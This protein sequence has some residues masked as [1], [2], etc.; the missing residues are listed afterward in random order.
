PARGRVSIRWQVPTEGLASLKVYDASG[1][2]VRTLHNGRTRPGAYRSVWNGRDDHNREVA[3]GIYFLTLEQNG[4][5]L[6]RKVVLA[7]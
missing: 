1:R 4:D 2:L 3:A 5:K 7:E 6:G